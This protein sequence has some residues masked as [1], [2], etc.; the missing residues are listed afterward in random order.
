[1]TAPALARRAATALAG[2]AAATALA[3]GLTAVA[4]APAALAATAPGH[5][6]HHHH[7]RR[8][9]RHDARR[10]HHGHARRQTARDN[11]VADPSGCGYPDATNTGVPAG[12]ALKQVPAQVTKG[13]GWAWN[14]SGWVE[15]TGNNAVL[16]DLSISGNLDI[17]GASNVTI[18]DVQVTNSGQS[19]MG[20][21][22]RHTT[23]V[24]IEDSTI[25]GVNSGSKRL[26]VGIKDVY[27]DATGTQVLDNNISLA[28]T[29]IQ[30]GTGLIQGNYI[31]DMGYIAGDHINGITSNGGTTG[32]LTITANTILVNN[33][34]TDAIGLFEDFGAQTNRTI[35]NNLLAGGSYTIY[36]GQNSGGPATSNIVVTGNRIATSYYANGGQYGPAT[37]YNPHGTGD[38]WSGNV[39]DNTGQ[40]I[41]AP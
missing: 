41:P 6:R 38:T 8:H 39:W 22:L 25:S 21:S 32:Q 19:S 14:P 27:G 4:G 26:M 30:I 13:T 31:H 5:A 7:A 36:A 10:H 12:T 9:H 18:K 24:T 28:S 29:G 23:N 40:A 35:S 1:M 34:Q 11:C 33:N 16:S 3:A 2:L 15:V 37:A 20:I 17:N